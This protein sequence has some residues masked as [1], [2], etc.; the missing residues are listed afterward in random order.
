MNVYRDT[1][2]GGAVEESLASEP[3]SEHPDDTVEERRASKPEIEWFRHPFTDLPA[4]ESHVHPH[5]VVLNA[6]MKLEG[7]DSFDMGVFTRRVADTYKITHWKAQRFINQI[8]FLNSEWRKTKVP[9]SFTRPVVAQKVPS[10][11]VAGG[12]S[13]EDR[14]SE[15]SSTGSRF[16]K[17]TM[18][19]VNYVRKRPSPSPTSSFFQLPGQ[20]SKRTKVGSVHSGNQQEA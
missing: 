4:L 13:G 1:L 18:A 5:W 20:E 6:G 15:K 19:A 2:P 14:G 7:I 12:I 17:A 10:P 9:E 11:R 16:V 8:I 3:K